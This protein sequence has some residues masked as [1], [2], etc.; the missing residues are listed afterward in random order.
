MNTMRIIKIFK[1]H[2]YPYLHRALYLRLLYLRSQVELDRKGNC[3]RILDTVTI[4]P[5]S[6]ISPTYIHNWSLRLFSQDYDLA[7]HNVSPTCP[8]FIQ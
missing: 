2:L 6:S 1:I 3:F 7:S 4:Q 5:G 8:F